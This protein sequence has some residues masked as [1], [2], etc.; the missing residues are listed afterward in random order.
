MIIGIRNLACAWQP[1]PCA[2]REYEVSVLPGTEG[3]EINSQGRPVV[4]HQKWVSS[5]QAK[6]LCEPCSQA[7]SRAPKWAG[8]R[9]PRPCSQGQCSWHRLRR[10]GRVSAAGPSGHTGQ[11]RHS[12]NTAPGPGGS[13]C[14]QDALPGQQCRQR[15]YNLVLIFP[16]YAQQNTAFKTS[17]LC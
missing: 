12:R 1:P 4:P 10:P 5:A 8:P 2:R 3:V 16:F 6:A 14:R 13:A 11:D 9:R 7:K 15:I 17:P